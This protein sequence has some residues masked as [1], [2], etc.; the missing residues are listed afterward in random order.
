MMEGPWEAKKFVTQYLKLD[1]PERLVKYRNY[2]QLDDER[3]PTPE[4]FLSHEP[5]GLDHWPTITTIQMG[6][7]KL[8]RV[9]YINFSADP[10]Y[11]VTY[12]LRTYVWV[13]GIGPEE[14]TETRDRLTAVVRS[15]LLD[16]PS[17]VRSEEKWF[18]SINV[19]SRLD[20]T[21]MKEEWSDLTYVKGDRIVAGAFIAYEFSLNET[22]MRDH[23]G[24]V[25]EF[26]IETV[27]LD[28]DGIR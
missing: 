23:N 4:L 15:A 12:N 28:W 6:T 1:I 16:H 18:P 19:E 24:S 10:V 5:L 8:E 9:D 26:D 20:E 21:T 13:R 2:W 3:L 7:S 17:M 14:V 11:R 25:S 22:I 27:S